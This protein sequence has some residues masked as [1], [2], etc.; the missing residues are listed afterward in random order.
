M[1]NKTC[2]AYGDITKY[3]MRRQTWSYCGQRRVGT[4]E[5]F[6]NIQNL[7]KLDGPCPCLV[8][9]I[10]IEMPYYATNEAGQKI[11]KHK[12][13]AVPDTY[14]NCCVGKNREIA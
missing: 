8:P 11:I 13:V 9:K 12:T 3:D 4:Q 6:P 10:D 5:G 14:R 7:P 2:D 1:R